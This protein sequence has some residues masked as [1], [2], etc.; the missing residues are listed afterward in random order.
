MSS[1]ISKILAAVCLITLALPAFP[2]N[3]KPVKKPDVPLY[4]GIQVGV[5]LGGPV[6]QLFSDNWSHSAKMDVNLKNKYFPTIEIGQA[7][8]DKT[9]AT[10][11]RFTSSGN[12]AKIG[13]LLPLATYGDRAENLFY[14]G[15]HYGFSS[16]NYNLDNLTYS[17]GY[18]GQPTVTS[19]ANEKAFAGWYDGEVGARVKVFGPISLG[20]SLHYRSTIHVSNG[21]HSV[22]AYIPGYGENVQPNAAICGHLYYRLPF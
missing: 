16:F 20:W 22:P 19:F 14:I 21:S 4:Q 1:F 7:N 6:C 15:L 5:E 3:I 2:K 9:G 11:I 13:V 17:G 18:W 8:I 10:G 12:F